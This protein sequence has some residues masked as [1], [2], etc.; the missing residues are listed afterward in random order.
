M[1]CL[2]RNKREFWYSLYEGKE[3]IT[4]EYGNETGDYKILRSN[5]KKGFANISA[6]QGELSTRLFGDTELYDKVIAYEVDAYPIDEYSVLW[7]DSVPTLDKD[8]ALATDKNGKIVTPYDYIVKKVATSLNNT[9]VAIT[10]VN[11][12]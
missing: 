4:N 8:E 1:K 9:S 10:K 12:S 11:V 2:L 3:P 7:I 6:A 5:P